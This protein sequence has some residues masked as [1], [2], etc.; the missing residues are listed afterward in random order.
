MKISLHIVESGFDDKRFHRVV[1][2]L[3]SASVEPEL[4]SAAATEIASAFSCGS[5]A[6]FLRAPDGKGA[7]L[8]G[9]TDNI[10]AEAAAYHANYHTLDF[11]AQRCL[12]LGPGTVWLGEELMPE[13]LVERSEF[14]NDW[15]KKTDSFYAAGGGFLVDTAAVG[16]FGLH[17]PKAAGAFDVGVKNDILRLFPHFQRAMQINRRLDGLEL[18]SRAALEGLE[19]L[20]AAV[21]V[22]DASGFVL[23]ANTRANRLLTEADG[24]TVAQGYLKA[25]RQ[26]DTEALLKLIGTASMV[27]CARD[28]DPGGAMGLPRGER[29][30]LS[31]LVCPASRNGSSWGLPRRPGAFIFIRN[32]DDGGAIAA[33]TIQ[34]LLGLTVAESQLA[35]SLAG[36][37]SIED[38]AAVRKTSLNTLRTQLKAIMAKTGTTR[39]SE[40]VALIF[41]TLP[42]VVP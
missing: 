32:P 20:A 39:Q 7:H 23:F 15:A 1:D 18:A 11:W 10:R 29:R 28:V 19:R 14:Y 2:F 24:I 4:W 35:A 16:V 25:A 30:P 42:C 36:G 34:S 8:T 12:S 26:Q 22:S 37:L 9:I 31:A 6:L 5:S 13:S 21:I 3:Y 27:P 41:R 17:R 38:V 33:R 40:L